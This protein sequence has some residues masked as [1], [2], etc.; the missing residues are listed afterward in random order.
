MEYE[1]H[2]YKSYRNDLIGSRR[3]LFGFFRM[4]DQHDIAT[5][6]YR[7]KLRRQGNS[8]LFY[9][10]HDA[11]FSIVRKVCPD[12]HCIFTRRFPWS[13]DNAASRG[14]GFEQSIFIIPLSI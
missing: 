12:H 1:D 6:A 8:H 5:E 9:L 2:Y 13:I 3:M 14:A 10:Q 11:C 4:S 7:P